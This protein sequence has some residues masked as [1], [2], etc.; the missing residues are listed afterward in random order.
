[1]RMTGVSSWSVTFVI[2]RLRSLR[3]KLAWWI[4]DYAF[5]GYWQMRAL[6]GSRRVDRYR[7]GDARPVLVIPGIWETWRFMLLLIR[8]IHEAGHPVYL[9]PQLRRNARPVADSARMVSEFVVANDLRDV[10]IVAHSKGGMIGKY[11]MAFQE[12]DRRISGMVAVATPFFGS[13]YAKYLILPSLRA[14]SPDDPTTLSLDDAPEV[15][16]RIVSVFGVFDPHI[17]AGSRLPG[18]QNIELPTG[19]HF[20]VLGRPETLTAVLTAAA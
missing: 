18:A 6:F 4:A 9:L 5:A 12:D 11:A 1:M 3:E 8:K 7:S 16:A 10:L 17:P 14:L 19:G 15:N 2:L 13:H 20:R